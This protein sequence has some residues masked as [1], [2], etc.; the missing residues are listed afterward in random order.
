[1]L[2]GLKL[3]PGPAA[4]HKNWAGS[5]PELGLASGVAEGTA[6]DVDGAG[7]GTADGEA[8]AGETADPS[9]PMS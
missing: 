2:F 8:G 5:A 9:P 6:D 4:F 7:V 1:M 3:P